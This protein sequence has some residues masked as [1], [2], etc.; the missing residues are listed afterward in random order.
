MYLFFRNC[1]DIVPKKLPKVVMK[2][3]EDPW[4]N[5]VAALCIEGN[6]LCGK[7]IEVKLVDE[8]LECW[9]MTVKGKTI[10]LVVL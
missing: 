1:W 10:G 5:K 7:E 3:I 6:L 9:N 2:K 4:R 8:N